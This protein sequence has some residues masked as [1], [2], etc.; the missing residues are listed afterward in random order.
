MNRLQQQEN[1]SPGELLTESQPQSRSMTGNF[2][3]VSSASLVEEGGVVEEEVR[4]ADPEATSTPGSW[5][6]SDVVGS[7][8]GNDL[9]RSSSEPGGRAHHTPVR[10]VSDWYLMLT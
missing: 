1:T 7:D 6:S 3:S 10:Q 2:Y 9:A 5:W 8:D 4:P